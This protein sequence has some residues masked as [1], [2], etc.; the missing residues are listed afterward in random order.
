MKVCTAAAQASS[1][2]SGRSGIMQV[3][4]LYIVLS[5]SRDVPVPYDRTTRSGNIQVAQELVN[6][7]IVCRSTIMRGKGSNKR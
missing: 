2:H 4:S 1:G 5:D 3:E 6:N 7:M